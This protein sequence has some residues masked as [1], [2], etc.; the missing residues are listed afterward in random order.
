M[1]KSAQSRN[2]QF[3]GPQL[4]HVENAGSGSQSKGVNGV[5]RNKKD[6]SSSR[7]RT[8]RDDS[9]STVRKVDDEAVQASE[10]RLYKDTKG[11][12]KVSFD[13]NPNNVP[14]DTETTQETGTSKRDGGGLW[15]LFF[16][17][18]VT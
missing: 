7:P 3:D 9:T 14:V 11:K 17:V 4:S 10:V 13:V 16:C 12:R 5:R 2:Q 15:S 18:A 6:H 1:E 8:G